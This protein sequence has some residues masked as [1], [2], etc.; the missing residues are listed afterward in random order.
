MKLKYRKFIGNIAR[1]FSPGYGTCYRCERPWTVCNGHTT[2]YNDSNGAFPLCEECWKE[3]LPTERWPYY[4][5][6]VI[7]WDTNEKTMQEMKRAV[8]DG[9]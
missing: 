8:F 5:R 4:K 2:M 1:I 6:L 7:S 3:L 9:K